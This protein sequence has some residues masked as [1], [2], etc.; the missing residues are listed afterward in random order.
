MADVFRVTADES[1]VGSRAGDRLIVAPEDSM[2]YALVRRLTR[3]ECDKVL[4]AGVIP[5][6]T[7]SPESRPAA[8][9]RHRRQRQ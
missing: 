6:R 2:P 7:P 3:A 9:Q 8:Q 1:D 5:V 4:A